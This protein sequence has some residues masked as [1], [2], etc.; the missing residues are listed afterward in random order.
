MAGHEQRRNAAARRFLAREQRRQLL[1][2]PVFPRVLNEEC[3]VFGLIGDEGECA[4]KIA[5]GLHALQ[6]RGQEAAGITTYDGKHFHSEKSLGLVSDHFMAEDVITE[7][8]GNAGI[9]H[10][11]YSTTGGSGLRNVQPFYA[12]LDR[13]GLALAHNGNLTNARTL[14]NDLIRQGRIFHTTSDTEIFV[15]LI[16]QSRQLTIADRIADSAP[17]VEGAYALIALT[18][19]HLIGLRDPVGIRPL[20]LG[21]LGTMPILSS[22]TCALELIGAEFV[23]EVAPGEMVICHADGM[24]ES[25]QVFPPVAKSRPCVFEL[26]Y[27]ARPN[28]FVEGNSVYELR[29]RLGAQLAAETPVEADVVCPIP[30]GGVPAAIGYA[31]AAGLPYDMGLIRGHYSGRTFIQPTQELREMGVARKHSANKGVVEGKRVIMIDDSIVRGT[32]SR[33][34]TRL[35]RDAGAKEVHFR[36]ASPPIEWPDYYGIDMPSRD[37]LMAAKF[38]IEEIRD[39][40]GAD[41]LG[42]LSVDGLYTALGRGPRGEVP[43]FSDHC[44]TG[45]YPT[46]LTDRDSL[47]QIAKVEQLSFLAE[48]G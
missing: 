44:F 32:T 30:D 10:T 6:H 17:I 9:G 16:S 20:V 46:P 23:R 21:K 15:K 5:L 2:P 24:V 11:R 14:R 34:L 26:I 28:S 48:S 31:N 27:F 41:S 1:T 25:R 12:D 36:I 37:D 19:D 35:L 18:Q 3:G 29:K 33:K 39:H 8:K 22:E 43:G 47:K 7:L 45:D 13:G 40:I 42:Y 38:S 4:T